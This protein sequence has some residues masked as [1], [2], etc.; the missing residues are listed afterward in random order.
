MCFSSEYCYKIWLLVG[1]GIFLKD[2][3]HLFMFERDTDLCLANYRRQWLVPAIQRTTSQWP[4]TVN[5]GA[6]SKDLD[7][8]IR[9][10]RLTLI[11]LVLTLEPEVLFLCASLDPE[12]L[13][14]PLLCS[15]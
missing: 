7:L 10:E 3:V 14:C 5:A 2:W 13:D 8:C 9:L 1:V 12:S 4:Y 11:P 15:G 6:K